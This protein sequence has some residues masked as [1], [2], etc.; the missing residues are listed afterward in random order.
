MEDQSQVYKHPP[1][2]HEILGVN[3]NSLL[4]DVA[5]PGQ[6]V[7]ASL[8]IG[9]CR[10]LH[11]KKIPHFFVE[12]VHYRDMLFVLKLEHSWNASGRIGDDM[13]VDT[14]FCYLECAAFA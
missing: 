6:R 14:K 7:P 3:T 10:T 12:Y 13:A 1:A 11:A 2:G 4:A 5:H 8:E 9:F